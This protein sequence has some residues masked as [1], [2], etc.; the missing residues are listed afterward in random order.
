MPVLREIAEDELQLLVDVMAAAMPREETGGVAGLA[1]WKRQAEAM[2][3]LLAEEEGTVVGAGYA[4]TGWHTPPHRAIGCAL[5]VPGSRGNGAGDEIRQALERWA[6]DHGATEL[7]GPVAEEDDGSMAWASARG[8]EESGRNSR[9][10]LDLTAIEAPEVSAPPGV[11]IV[12]WA[13]EPE[14][15]EGLWEVAREAG[16]D[17]PGEEETDVGPLEEWLDRDMRGGGDRPE[18]VFAALEDGEVLGYAKLS[19]SEETTERAFHDLTGVKR[20]HRG[21]GIAAALKATQIAWAKANGFRS[22]QTAN[23]VRNAPIRHLN[24]KHGYV[25]EPGVVIVRRT[26]A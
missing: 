6:A 18:A 25:L 24:A 26:L 10:V 16:P 2:V 12:T 23:E 3:W 9:M 15:A 17:I 1:D 19:F 14:L 11:E 22:L 13:E 5:V 21:R 7:E 20:A 4:L 8:Y